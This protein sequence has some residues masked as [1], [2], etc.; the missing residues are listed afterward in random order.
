VTEQ[1]T[2][3]QMREV[4]R[5]GAPAQTSAAPA[6]RDEIRVSPEPAQKPSPA[7]AENKGLTRRQLREQGLLG[8][9]V[10]ASGPATNPERAENPAPTGSRRAM[11]QQPVGEVPAPNIDVPPADFGGANL[12]AEPSTES[13]ILQRAPEAIELPIETGEITVTG[14]IQ[15]VTDTNPVT[16]ATDA[17]GL[18]TD[19]DD[20]AVTGVLSTTEPKS[21]LELIG[22]R[23]GTGVVPASM[24]RGKWKPVAYAA[25]SV[26]L[27]AATIWATIVIIGAAG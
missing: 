11:R 18:D 27:A 1:L 21:A 7:S 19:L 9:S 6:I 25:G 14:S 26:A 23:S 12:L 4:E 2:R 24:S 8:A 5:G 15:I 22:E 13:I 3:R 20:D 17:I 10:A 16:T